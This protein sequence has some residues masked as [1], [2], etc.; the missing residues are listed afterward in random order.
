MLHVRFAG[1]HG[2]GLKVAGV[3]QMIYLLLH[4]VPMLPMC[5]NP[6]KRPT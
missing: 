1:L 5:R 4:V 6:V 3:L 2:L